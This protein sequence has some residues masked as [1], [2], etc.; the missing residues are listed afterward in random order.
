MKIS[1]LSKAGME[2]LDADQRR[3]IDRME[4][5]TGRG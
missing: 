3:D 4:R 1:L 5:Q 2:E